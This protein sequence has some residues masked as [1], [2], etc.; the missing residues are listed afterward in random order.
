[1]G[2]GASVVPG[3]AQLVEIGFVDYKYGLPRTSQ[4]APRVQRRPALFF[5]LSLLPPW[6]RSCP[7]YFSGF[8]FFPG[9]VLSAEWTM[10]GVILRDDDLIA[11]GNMDFDRQ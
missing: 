9:L 5:V 10:R 6:A 8:Q 3:W 1:M 2:E 11:G 7:L 4:E